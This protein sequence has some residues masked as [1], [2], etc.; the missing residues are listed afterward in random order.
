MIDEENNLLIG[1]CLE[2]NFLEGNSINRESEAINGEG[3]RSRI[4]IS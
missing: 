3:K 4:E 2:E 1:I